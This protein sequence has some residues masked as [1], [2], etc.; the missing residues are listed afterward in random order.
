[1]NEIEA[2][3]PETQKIPVTPGSYRCF[4]HNE[5]V[6]VNASEIGAEGLTELWLLVNMHISACSNTPRGCNEDC[7]LRKL[8]D[9]LR[10]NFLA[11]LG[12]STK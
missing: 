8:R 9:E 3:N 10:K 6:I 7:S 1:M 11:S 2:T 12:D 5:G 4:V